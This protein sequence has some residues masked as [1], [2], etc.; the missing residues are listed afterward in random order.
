MSCGSALL[1]AMPMPSLKYLRIE[2]RPALQLAAGFGVRTVEPEDEADAVVEQQRYG[3][4]HEGVARL[5]RGIEELDLAVAKEGA[6]ILLMR[7]AFGH[8]DLLALEVS[9]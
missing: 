7:R 3:P 6:Q 1:T 2:V 9:G 4:V 8:G 5:F